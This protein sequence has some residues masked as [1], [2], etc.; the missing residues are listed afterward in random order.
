LSTFPGLNN[1]NIPTVLEDVENLRNLWIEAPKARNVKVVTKEGLETFQL[2]QEPAS[3][4]RL[5]LYGMLPRKLKNLTISGAGFNRL[6][7]GILDVSFFIIF[8]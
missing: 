5:E 4:L 1:F 2:V 3:D 7:D 8:I 6:A